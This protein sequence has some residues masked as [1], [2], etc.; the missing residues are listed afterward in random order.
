MATGL[1]TDESHTCLP[2]RFWGILYVAFPVRQFRHLVKEKKRE[3]SSADI[4]PV[5]HFLMGWLCCCCL[6]PVLSAVSLCST[7]LQFLRNLKLKA[8][9]WL[10]SRFLTAGRKSFRAK[11]P[12]VM[13]TCQ[14]YRDDEISP[15][16]GRALFLK[17]TKGYRRTLTFPRYQL[18]IW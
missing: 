16:A 12:D 6:Q 2:I 7:L 13:A 8:W 15:I 9:L 5:S 18:Q 17:K 10:L 4:C 14:P 3:K 11:S 1:F